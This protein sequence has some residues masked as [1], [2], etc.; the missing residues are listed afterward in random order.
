MVDDIREGGNRADGDR[1][2]GILVGE[3]PADDAP[4]DALV[5][6][7]LVVEHL[8]VACPVVACPEDEYL[9]DVGR[10]R[11]IAS[12]GHPLRADAV[13]AEFVACFAGN[14]RPPHHSVALQVLWMVDPY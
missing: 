14:H 5:V 9:E 13:L 10:L 11:A 8:E 7:L 2:G 4:D 3:L 12:V 6:V 1:V